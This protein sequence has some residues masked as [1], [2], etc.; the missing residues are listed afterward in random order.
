MQGFVVRAISI[1]IVVSLLHLYFLQIQSVKC[2]LRLRNLDQAA[3]KVLK[4]QSVFKQQPLV[5]LQKLHEVHHS[6][7]SELVFDGAAFT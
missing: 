2:D 5:N 4:E 3:V 6:I 1:C 7:D